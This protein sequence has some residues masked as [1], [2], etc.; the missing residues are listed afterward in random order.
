MNSAIRFELDG[1]VGVLTFTSPERLNPLSLDLQSGAREILA[2]VRE[3]SQVRAVLLKGEGRGFCV[4]ADL[5]S[6]SGGDEQSTL[7]E[8]VADRA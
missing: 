7:G 4:G 8:R 3:N 2:R 5:N 1:D 6:M